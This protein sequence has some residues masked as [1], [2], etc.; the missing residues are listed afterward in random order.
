MAI[1]WARR[2]AS[3][4]AAGWTFDKRTYTDVWQVRTSEP[5]VGQGFVRNQFLLGAPYNNITE[6]DPGAWCKSVEVRQ[7]P[8]AIIWEVTCE[9]DSEWR[10]ADNPNPLLRPAEYRYRGRTILVSRTEDLDGKKFVNSAGQ[11]FDV[12]E[13]GIPF[14]IGIVEFSV[15]V[16][17]YSIAQVQEWKNGV[18]DAAFFGAA[19]GTLKLVDYD[20]DPATETDQTGFA[21]SYF[22][23]SGSIE[24]KPDGW[25]VELLNKGKVQKNQDGDKENIHDEHGQ[26]INEEVLLDAAGK[27][28]PPNGTPTY[29]TF[30]N[31]EYI[32]FTLLGLV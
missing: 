30:R 10:P 17:T 24:Y 20:G 25:M 31:L 8:S 6:N 11:P 5:T 21:Y 3:G 29:K 12:S 19:K 32:D 28:L 9:Y 2:V 26:D 23:V 14:N 22:R 15:N 18:N 16:A 27:K 7:G 4:R 13:V 1:V